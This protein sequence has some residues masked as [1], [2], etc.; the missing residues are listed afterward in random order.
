MFGM[1][2]KQLRD[3]LGLHRKRYG[4]ARGDLARARADAR[5]GGQGRTQGVVTAAEAEQIHLFE[6]KVQHE[7]MLINRRKKQIAAATPSAVVGRPHEAF[8]ISVPNQSARAVSVPRLIVLHTTESSQAAGVADLRAIGAWFSNP[9]AQASSHVCV[10]GDGNSA[11]FVPDA[12][13]A[14]AQ[15]AYNSVALSIE[16]IGRASQAEFPEAQLEKTAQYVAYWSRKYGIPI[17]R[18]TSHGV[19]QHAD[20]GAAGGGHHDCGSKYPFAKVLALARTMV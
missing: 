11:Q 20:L 10:D 18:S 13:K 3:S 14:W 7:L 1:N 6:E 8:V 9:R 19:C 17:V 5:A 2:L 12:R 15:A 4:W 16:Q